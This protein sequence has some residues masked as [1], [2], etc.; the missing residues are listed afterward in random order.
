[1]ASKCKKRTEVLEQNI[2]LSGSHLFLGHP[3]KTMQD[4]IL[5]SKTLILWMLY[6]VALP[7]C[8][9]TYWTAWSSWH[10]YESICWQSHKP[11]EARGAGSNTVH[12]LQE[13]VTRKW[14]ISLN[15]TKRSHHKMWLNIRLQAL[16]RLSGVSTWPV[17][18]QAHL[19]T[20]RCEC[21]VSIAY[22]RTFNQ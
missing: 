19:F 8:S 15:C 10:Q 14:Q 3:R 12:L 17:T 11:V 18:M 4:Q 20:H 16:M 22:F 7:L 9:C 1:M 5:H 13:A 2:L 21:K 6:Y